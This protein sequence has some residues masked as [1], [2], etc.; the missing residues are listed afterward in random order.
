[1]YSAWSYWVFR[2]KVRGEIGYQSADAEE[3]LAQN[4]R[5]HEIAE[6]TRQLTFVRGGALAA[7][8][9]QM[10][11]SLCARTRRIDP[12]AYHNPSLSMKAA[13][14]LEKLGIKVVLS[15]AGMGF[16]RLMFLPQLQEI[17]CLDKVARG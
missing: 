13:K 2:G 1:M 7:W 9:T 4:L 17:G 12:R 6:W 8:I 10:V 5:A 3:I 11:A 15:L 16:V 14:R